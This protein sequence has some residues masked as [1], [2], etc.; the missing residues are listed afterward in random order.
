MTT[1]LD[2]V[3]HTLYNWFCSNCIEIGIPY[4]I[5]Q[6]GLVLGIFFMF[7]VAYL[8][9]R[10]VVMLIDCGIKTQ[11]Y[12]LEVISQHTMGIRGYFAA[13]I[14][15]FLNAYGAQIAY[16]VIIADTV[17]LAA[18][19]L[20][21]GSFLDERHAAL[22]FFATVV[23]LPISLLRD[24]SS[25]S[26]TSLLSV[27]SVIVLI[28]IVGIWAPEASQLQNRHFES[29]DAGEVNTNLFAGVGTMSFAFVCQH[30]S[31]LIYRSL[32]QPSS[33]S[34]RTVAH[35]SVSFSFVVSLAFGLI[36]FFSFF[37]Y[38]EGDLLN[39]FP[40]SYTSVAVARIL[41]A[42]TMLFTYPMELYVS[43]HC[44]AQLMSKWKEH[45]LLQAHQHQ[46]QEHRGHNHHSQNVG[47]E[48]PSIAMVDRFGPSK[49]MS[50]ILPHH[51]R[52]C[53]S[54]DEDVGGSGGG[55]GYGHLEGDHRNKN[56]NGIE[57]ATVNP[58]VPNPTRYHNPLERQEEHTASSS[59]GSR[60]PPSVSTSAAAADQLSGATG[61]TIISAYWDHNSNNDDDAVNVQYKLARDGSPMEHKLHLCSRSGASDVAPVAFVTTEGTHTTNT[62]TNTLDNIATTDGNGAPVTSFLTHVLLTLALW[63][64][65]VGVAFVAEQLGVVTGLA[66]LLLEGPNVQTIVFD[67][68]GVSL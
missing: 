56:T 15:M 8:V 43:R 42:I 49:Q 13:L 41:L 52:V 5:Q 18:Q 31:F 11:K 25:L 65:T 24:L 35:S 36:G 68:L 63:S 19:N 67:A 39:N 60:V 33:E 55:S 62:N 58:M 26:W 54:S 27:L 45:R 6:C 38:V 59:T 61:E 23:V 2:S 29:S 48:G 32:K 21:P 9:D 7:L 17:P 3:T 28:M 66:G 46:V 40:V 16:L 10:S 64:T 14:F 47:D 12:D 1:G 34:W 44:L 22:L 57:F 20:F 37:P 50:S 30:N 53:S 4:A 51:H